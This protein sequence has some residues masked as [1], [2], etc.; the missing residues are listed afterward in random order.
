MQAAIRMLPWQNNN[1]NHR[2]HP[3]NW[4]I[5]ASSNPD[6]TFPIISHQAAH[7]TH[8]EAAPG[9]L[10]HHYTVVEC[11]NSFQSIAANILDR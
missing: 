8:A 4:K 7:A 2:D 10:Q 9:P 5:Y 11:K 6:P 3:H 1:H